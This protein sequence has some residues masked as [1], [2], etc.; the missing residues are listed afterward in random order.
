[1][2]VLQPVVKVPLHSTADA[3]RPAALLIGQILPVFSL[4]APSGA[5]ASA[6]SVPLGTFTTDGKFPMLAHRSRGPFECT[7]I[8]PIRSVP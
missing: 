6:L 1:M 4:V 7:R 8:V 2:R 5:G 3:S